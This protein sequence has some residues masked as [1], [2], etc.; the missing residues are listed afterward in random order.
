MFKNITVSSAVVAGSRGSLEV[1]H[2]D[3][4][5]S[6][7]ALRAAGKTEDAARELASRDRLTREREKGL[8]LDDVLGT[9][10]HE[11]RAQ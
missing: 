8:S 1:R 2:S 10:K 9:I 11:F 4:N 6:V 7:S 3:S 5:A